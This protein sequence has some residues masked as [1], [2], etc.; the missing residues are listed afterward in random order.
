MNKELIRKA[1]GGD[2]DCQFEVGMNFRLGEN[3]FPV[4]IHKA[5]H[6]LQMAAMAGHAK[7]CGNMAWFYYDIGGGTIEPKPN[8]DK[9][10]E[11]LEL[12]YEKGLERAANDLVA[13]LSDDEL[14][15]KNKSKSKIF[16]KWLRELAVVHRDAKHMLEYGLLLCGE[17]GNPFLKLYPDLRSHINFNEGLKYIS[18]SGADHEYTQH[19]RKLTVVVAEKNRLR[20]LESNVSS[21]GQLKELLQQQ[22]QLLKIQLEYA[23]DVL[24]TAPAAMKEN[25]RRMVTLCEGE[26]TANAEALQTI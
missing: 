8:G 11:W 19:R 7:A 15:I 21:K 17:A 16:F 24:R 10:V 5:F 26:L 6:Y 12:A 9:V 20:A 22:D 23:R 18:N 1:D 25:E 3:G 13:M 4:D 14:V 2:H